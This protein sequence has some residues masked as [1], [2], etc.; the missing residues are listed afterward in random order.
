VADE[1]LTAPG[2]A[3]PAVAI[4]VRGKG[5]NCLGVGIGVE[6]RHCAVTF[7]IGDHWGDFRTARQNEAEPGTW[8][9]EGQVIE[10]RGIGGMQAHLLDPEGRRSE[11]VPARPTTED[12]WEKG[13]FRVLLPLNDALGQ[14]RIVIALG[15]QES[16]GLPVP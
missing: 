1:L 7:V 11:P 15:D 4:L 13:R 10:G 2:Q 9:V 14:S 16:T 6:G 12:G 8:V 5:W 3:G